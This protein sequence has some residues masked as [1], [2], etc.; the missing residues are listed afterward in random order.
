MNRRAFFDE[1]VFPGFVKR[2]YRTGDLVR[3]LPDGNLLFIGRKD[4]QIKIRGYRVELDEVENVLCSF[5]EVAEAAAIATGTTSGQVEVVGVVVLKRMDATTGEA[6]R[7][8]ASEHLPPYAVPGRVDVRETLPRTPTGKI[9]RRA[10]AASYRPE[11][12][13]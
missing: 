11:E 12:R 7:R 9:D 8:R 6:L 1:E 2:F 3:E 5:G 13:A 4:R 10:L